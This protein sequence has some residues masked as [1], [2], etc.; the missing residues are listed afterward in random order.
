MAVF[1]AHKIFVDVNGAMNILWVMLIT[2]VE[3]RYNML[4]AGSKRR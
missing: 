1:K 4:V 3:E 2:R